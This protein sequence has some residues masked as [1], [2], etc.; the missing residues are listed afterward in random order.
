MGGTSKE[1]IGPSTVCS[2]AI[3]S[4]CEASSTSSCNSAT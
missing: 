4:H 2:P 1:V 3:S